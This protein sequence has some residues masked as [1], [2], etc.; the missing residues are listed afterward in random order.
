MKDWQKDVIVIISFPEKKFIHF[1]LLQ[2]Y[3]SFLI[4]FQNLFSRQRRLKWLCVVLYVNPDIN[5]QTTD[6]E[7]ILKYN[8]CWLLTWMSPRLFAR[9]TSYL[10]IKSPS[11]S[12][13]SQP[14]H[15]LCWSIVGENEM[16]AWQ[17][18][19][20]VQFGPFLLLKFY[21]LFILFNTET[22]T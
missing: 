11:I 22:R 20:Y 15:F 10:M 12:V 4:F 14:G 7:V 3:H 8:I 5:I 18:D 21:M 19:K 9:F 13:S 16:W 17:E 2:F 6:T 1:M